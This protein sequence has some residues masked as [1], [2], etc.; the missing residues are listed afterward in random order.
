MSPAPDPQSGVIGQ[1]M[2]DPA[3]RKKLL[4]DPA[5]TLRRAGVEVPEGVTI[6]VVEDT[7]TKVHLVLPAR[8]DETL[9]S[10]L[11]AAVG[12]RPPGCGPT[13]GITGNCGQTY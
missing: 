2:S 13:C 7:A 5:G 3:F 11:D 6:A 10:D 1:A 12:G 8:E 4:A 9:D